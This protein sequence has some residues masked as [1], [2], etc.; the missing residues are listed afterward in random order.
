MFL[1]LVFFLMGKLQMFS[2][3]NRYLANG[4]C[5]KNQSLPR[6][7][8][9][10][11]IKKNYAGQTKLCNTN[12]HLLCPNIYYNTIPVSRSLSRHPKICSQNMIGLI[13][14]EI[15]GVL[16]S[17]LFVNRRISKIYYSQADMSRIQST[18]INGGIRRNSMS[19]FWHTHTQSWHFLDLMLTHN[20]AMYIKVLQIL[21][22]K[23]TAKFDLHCSSFVPMLS[24]FLLTSP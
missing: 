2:V 18:V 12:F 3:W 23:C 24:K 7:Y 22:W 15:C 6:I 4:S 14:N 8:S 9:Y 21:P 19:S 20:V 17:I 16:A 10:G 5:V 1:S 13:I 11:A